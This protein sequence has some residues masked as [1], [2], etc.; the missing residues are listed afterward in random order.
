MF[1]GSNNRLRYL[2]N[3][4][5]LTKYENIIICKKCNKYNSYSPNLNIKFIN[6]IS[7]MNPLFL[8]K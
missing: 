7:C 3:Q 8:H 5:N 6:C 2:N 1:R 4:S